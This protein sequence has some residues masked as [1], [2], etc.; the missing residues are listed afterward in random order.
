MIQRKQALA[1]THWSK[2]EYDSGGRDVWDVTRKKADL[3][4]FF[5]AHSY[6]DL[7]EEGG[8][9]N[10]KTWRHSAALTMDKM[11]SFEQRQWL[12]SGKTAAGKDETGHIVFNDEPD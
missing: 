10:P 7:S 6:S 12:K 9:E 1:G 4:T 5:T 8:G 11:S 2:S 3:N